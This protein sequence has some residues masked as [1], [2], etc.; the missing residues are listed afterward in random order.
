MSD[1]K[2]CISCG[3]KLNSKAIFCPSCGTKQEEIKTQEEVKKQ[4][5]IKIN[6][7]AR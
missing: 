5:E 2:K 6:K 4:E 7:I 3:N 1:T